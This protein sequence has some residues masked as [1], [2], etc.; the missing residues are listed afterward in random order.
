MTIKAQTMS[1]KGNNY[2]KVAERLR[3]FRQDHPDGKTESAY[4]MDVD[5]TAVFNVWIWKNKKE[6]LELMK[7]GVTDKEVLRSSADANGMAK[8]SIGNKDKDFEKLET[9]ATGRG[10][11]FLGYLASGEIASSEEMEEFLKA[12]QESLDTALESIKNAKTQDELKTVFMSLGRLK[13]NQDI[14]QAKDERK[15]Q[16]A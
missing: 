11:A 13:L 8:G 1:L 14:I 12:K 6:L 7:A 9:V 10:L 16:L 2:A 4:D 3:L 15:A 5:G